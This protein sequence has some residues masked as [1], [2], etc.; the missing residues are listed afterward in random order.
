MTKRDLSELIE[1]YE[2]LSFMIH[3]KGELLI[4]EQIQSEL[5]H[6]QHITLHYIRMQTHCT[7][8]DLA[9]LFH[10]NKSAITAL[11]N[12]LEEKGLINRERDKEDRRLVHLSLTEK[13]EAVY[14]ACNEK[15]QA[16]VEGFI[17]QFS[18]EEIETFMKTYEK[19]ALILDQ[20]IQVKSD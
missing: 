18:D 4:N 10:V 13:G 8:S 6:D 19:L 1:R 17:S 11:I 5:T 12:R 14:K 15:I 3:K 2:H 20:T 16:V 9:Q 7:S